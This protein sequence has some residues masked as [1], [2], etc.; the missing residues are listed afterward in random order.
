[1]SY[2]ALWRKYNKSRLHR[3]G[4]RFESVT[5]HHSARG[6]GR[7]R[8]AATP[9]AT[10]HLL[11]HLGL[12]HAHRLADLETLELRVPE[13]ERLVVPGGVMRGPER[14]AL[15]PGLD[16]GAVLPHRVGGIKRVI[17]GF[18]ALE[19]VELDEA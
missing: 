10:P 8:Q 14:C 19:Q 3:E 5:A 9:L 4:R 18:G 7:L 2:G 1:M 12:A 13:I 6:K 15:G 16:R 17:L 11:R